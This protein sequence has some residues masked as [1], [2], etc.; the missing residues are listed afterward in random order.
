M[1]GSYANVRRP[2]PKDRRVIN[3]YFSLRQARGRWARQP[4]A[5]AISRTAEQGLH[6]AIY[7]KHFPG[8]GS[9]LIG[10][11]AISVDGLA[12]GLVQSGA[13][14]SVLCEGAARTTV[15]AAGGY[16]IECF[17]NHRQYRTFT[18]AP[19]LRR[20]VS[21]YLTQ[22]Q[23]LCLVN[24]MF[25]PGAYA[26][27]RLLY[28]AGVPYVAVPHD[29][30]DRPVFASNAHLKWP[31]W[32]LFERRL[33][34]RA[35]AVQVLDIRHAVC[36]R[37]LGIETPCLET[38]NG[39]AAESVPA[40]SQLQWRG[41]REAV[42]LVFLGRIDAYNKGLDTLLDAFAGISKQV[43]MRLTVQGPDWGDRARLEKHAV[44]ANI[45][46][47]VAFRGP[48]YERSSTQ[49]IGD[50]DIFCLASRFE[51]FGLAA[52]EAMLAA[53]VLLVSEG[54]GIAHH[55][56]ASG[57]GVTVPSTVEGIE[58]GLQKLLRLRASWRE[59]GLNGR[60][61]ALANLQWKNIGAAARE[62]YARLLS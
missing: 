58:Q 11:T 31:Y 24:G 51:G 27:G 14:V 4:R 17:C 5:A 1:A 10:G 7:L 56:R 12:A 9:P 49:I 46:D 3:G 55:V 37:R 32:Y 20:Y 40:E 36:L 50:H 60:R 16:T 21:E 47:R 57:C 61:Y 42:H 35:H 18:L 23:G 59:M 44:A 54:A 41:P 29:P 15:K 48:D 30:Y 53:R 26:M 8:A 2:N 62:R 13:D 39:I 28:Q 45:S 6:I 33:L 34:L 25:H 19:E 22:R 38:P 43:D 52:L